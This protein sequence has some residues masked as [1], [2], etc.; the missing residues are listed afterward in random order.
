MD[1]PRS[2]PLAAVSPLDGRYA[3]LTAPL[4]PYASESALIRARVRVEIE[5]LLALAA[6]DATPV[7]TGDGE[8]ADLRAVYEEFDAED[9]RLVK[10]I[11][12]E[13]AAGYDATHHDV[14]AVEYFLR[15]ETDERLH[16]W[17]HFGLTSEDVTNLARRLLIHGAVDEVLLPAIREIRDRLAGMAREY[18][19]LPMLARTHGQPATP[20]TFGKELAVFAVRLGA[21]GTYA[22]HTVA[23]PDVDWPAFARE[24]VG[25]LGLDHEPVTT[26]V[27]PGDDLAVLF[28][29]LEATNRVLLDLVRDCWAY[30]SRDY[31]GQRA[32]DD[33]TGSSTMPHKVNPISFENA[34][35]NLTAANA[36]LST[37]A[38]EV[39]TSRLQRDL[40]DSTVKRTVGAAFG[41][42]LIGYRRTAAGLETVVPNEAAMRADLDAHPEVLGEA[43]QMVLRAAG[44]A[45]AYERV[46]ELTRGRET[47]RADL[48]ELL[49]SLDL[50]VADRERLA[51]MEP[52]D[53]TGVAATLVDEL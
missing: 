1:L 48:R 30:V 40:S 8:A 16:P 25:G 13:G 49:A 14:K 45:D 31:L 32:D 46:K 19:D 52:A 12:T 7:E 47:T 20:T 39:T 28:D 27:N 51:D 22:A 35:G 23:Y 36:H 41:H 29:A 6:L 9:A 18:R 34:E 44:H 11:E 2:D 38:G 50:A 15:T 3:D 17:V 37:L 26:Q 42:G 43:V 21:T 24:F 53:Y 5:Y 10:R 33:T 4:V